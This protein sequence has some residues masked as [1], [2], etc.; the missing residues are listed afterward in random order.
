MKFQKFKRVLFVGAIIVATLIFAACSQATS[1]ELGASTLPNG[2]TVSA[3]EMAKLKALAPEAYAVRSRVV[4]S[5][6]IGAL[7]PTE[8]ATLRDQYN[9]LLKSQFGDGYKKFYLVEEE[10]VS[11]DGKSYVQIASEAAHFVDTDVQANT[12]AREVTEVNMPAGLYVKCT[13]GYNW[14]PWDSW[15]WATTYVPYA[16]GTIT[17]GVSDEYN[18]VG[19]LQSASNAVT[20]TKDG[21]GCKKWFSK[22]FA[23]VTTHRAVWYGSVTLDTG[24]LVFSWPGAN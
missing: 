23:C 5:R 21:I 12:S 13:R 7:S 22:K 9:A 8:Y 16:A 11:L 14:W 2:V 17:A 1:S 3:E 15:N 6:D 19:T 18:T 20:V 4:G 24:D 10:S